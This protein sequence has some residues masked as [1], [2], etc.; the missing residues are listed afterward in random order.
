[1][2]ELILLGY[3]FISNSD[4]EVVLAAYQQWGVDCQHKF[5]GMWA[6]VIYDC[7]KQVIFMSRDRFGIKPLYYWFSPDGSFCFASEIKQFTVLHG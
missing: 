7:E 5:N 6:F 3:K 2:Q 4:T 1:M